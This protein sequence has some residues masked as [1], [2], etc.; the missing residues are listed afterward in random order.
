MDKG[1]VWEWH[2]SVDGPN[3]QSLKHFIWHVKPLNDKVV[4]VLTMMA[5]TAEQ[6]LCL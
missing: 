1:N 5:A 2:T 4:L 3:L 6:K